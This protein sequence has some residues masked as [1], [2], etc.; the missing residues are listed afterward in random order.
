MQNKM[1][2]S[3]GSTWY[4]LREGTLEEEEEGEPNEREMKC[5]ET[6]G[7]KNCHCSLENKSAYAPIA[8]TQPCYLQ[9]GCE[10]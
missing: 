9:M 5:E 4:S 7:E 2:T 1:I 6:S 10:S 8:F 3:E